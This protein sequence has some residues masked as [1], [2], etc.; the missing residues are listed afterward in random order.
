MT[1]LAQVVHVVKKDLRLLRWPLAAFAVVLMTVAVLD[2]RDTQLLGSGVIPILAVIAGMLLIT[3]LVQEQSP[4]AANA[5]WRV[6]PLSPVAVFVAKLLMLLMVLAVAGAAEWLALIRFDVPAAHAVSLTSM[7][8]APYLY[9]LLTAA[10]IASL[11]RNIRG[12]V[13]ALILTPIGLVIIGLVFEQA[14]TWMGLSFET[15]PALYR[16]LSYAALAAAPLIVGGLYV[17]VLPRWAA[18]VLA[19]GTSFALMVA[20]VGVGSS[21]TFGDDGRAV[22]AAAMSGQVTAN[23][24]AN[25]DTLRP[26]L[27]V[28]SMTNGADTGDV[29]LDVAIDAAMGSAIA[30]TGEDFASTSSAARNAREVLDTGTLELIFP[31]G[32]T[33]RTPIGEQFVLEVRSSAEFAEVTRRGTPMPV[34][35]ESS[36]Q[37]SASTSAT[38]IDI[39]RVNQGVEIRG[40]LPVSLVLAEPMRVPD[41]PLAWPRRA[42]SHASL[43]VPGLT[44][45][46]RMALV[47]GSVRARV[48]GSGRSI[49][50]RVSARFVVSGD[51]KGRVDQRPGLRVTIADTMR[52]G[53]ASDGSSATRAKLLTISIIDGL[54]DR[55]QPALG[56]GNVLARGE[57][58]MLDTAGGVAEMVRGAA[59]SG[60]TGA[61]LLPGIAQW[62][63]R[64]VLPISDEGRPFSR[65]SR[66]ALRPGAEV[67]MV[68]W[69]RG[70]GRRIESRLATVGRDSTPR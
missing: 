61:L 37:F 32:T 13:A 30:A 14:T 5:S 58:L 70:T 41:T 26:A 36:T 46:Q 65:G 48:S 15:P 20:L 35:G 55:L 56:I 69:E 59:S 64:Y 6:L 51:T 42:P 38:S 3:T 54:H 43:R 34:T 62:T 2:D 66:T 17:R 9:W 27:S 25:L 53:G 10:L 21:A 28:S 23:A 29:V 40:G 44:A 24:E 8:L 11:T 45:S 33:H 12:F 1:P 67:M 19:V 7:T 47:A 50:P 49:P 63:S 60:H 68:S 22:R 39:A 52:A 4:S 16:W 31:D 18:R 57:L